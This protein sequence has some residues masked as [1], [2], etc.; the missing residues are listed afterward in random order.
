MKIALHTND[1]SLRGVPTSVYKYGHFLEKDGYDVVIMYDKNHRYNS[2]DGIKNFEERFDMLPYNTWDEA[3][4][5]ISKNNVDV[6]YMQKGGRN[7]GKLSQHAKTVIHAVFQQHEPH[8][9]KYAY[10]SKWLSDTMPGG[11]DYVPYIVD[12][13]WVSK[14]DYLSVIPAGSTVFGRIGGYDEFN[15]PFVQK[16][17]ENIAKA[18]HNIYFLLVNTKPFCDLPNVIHINK[19]SFE[20][21]KSHFIQACDAM[22]HARNMG[23]SFGLA[24]AEFLFYDK[25]VISYNGGIDQNH[26]S[27]LGEFGHWYSN[28][29]SF[30]DKVITFKRKG[31]GV[32][33][34]LVEDFSP[35][36]V[37]TK[38]KKVFLDE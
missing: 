14:S 11:H 15:I 22:I 20:I 27:M 3:D 13:P 25:P 35:E 9:E 29:G 23:E 33:K 4:R 16:S 19:I 36:K 24:I 18:H 31:D 26:I 21:N 34:K 30:I 17:I 10:I 32:Y 8:G 28:G 2:L 38:F 6:I 5:L 37:I 1:I 7:D 12:L